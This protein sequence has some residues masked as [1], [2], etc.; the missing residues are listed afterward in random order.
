[1]G[2]QIFAPVCGEDGKTHSNSCFA[3]CAGTSVAHKGRCAKKTPA[4]TFPPCACTKVPAPAPL[5]KTNDDPSGV[6]PCE[7]QGETMPV[8]AKAEPWGE[9]CALI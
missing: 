8:R 5:R 1:M 4:P 9:Q 2:A 3:K 7:L 6:S